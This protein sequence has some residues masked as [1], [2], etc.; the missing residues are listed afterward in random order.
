MLLW[1]WYQDQSQYFLK[2]ENNLYA[3]QEKV[4]EMLEQMVREG[5]LEP[6]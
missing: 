2:P 3:L 1:I 6:V 5:S 4:T